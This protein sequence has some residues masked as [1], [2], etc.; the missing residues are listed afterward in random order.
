MQNRLTRSI[1]EK[2][3]VERPG[4]PSGPAT[5]KR[6]HERWSWRLLILLVLV[7]L[8]AAWHAGTFDHALYNVGLNAKPCARNGFGAVFCG[9]ELTEYDEHIAQGKREGEAAGRKIEEAGEKAQ[10]EGESI[11]R[12]AQ[13]HTEEAEHA[14]ESG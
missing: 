3:G 14:P 1:E 4:P 2:H 11:E 13:R 8:F 5:P 10:R 6:W 12:E 9:Q 7:F